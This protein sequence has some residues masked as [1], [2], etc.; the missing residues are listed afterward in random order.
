MK[1]ITFLGVLIFCSAIAFGQPLAGVAKF[2]IPVTGLTYPDKLS[3]HTRNSF[4]ASKTSSYLSQ[5]SDLSLAK[6]YAFFD[7]SDGRLFV[8]G[9]VEPGNKDAKVLPLYTLGVKAN[10]KDGFSTLFD[11]NSSASDMGISFKITLLGNGKIHS[12]T[13]GGLNTPHN[14]SLNQA[15][16]R[17][18]TDKGNIEI[19]GVADVPGVGGISGVKDDEEVPVEQK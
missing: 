9:T 19:T 7:N 5:A 3:N 11:A 12:N 17:I 4:F 1:K 13:A 10:V 2:L 18:G 15:H 6:A 8:G 14:V 16:I